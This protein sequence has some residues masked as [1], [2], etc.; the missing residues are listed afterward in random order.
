MVVTA[1]FSATGMVF[2]ACR[3]LLNMSV[4]LT[5]PL[6]VLMLVTGSLMLVKKDDFFSYLEDHKVTGQRATRGAKRPP[7]GPFVIHPPRPWPPAACRRRTMMR[8]W[9]R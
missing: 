1:F 3:C 5:V 9:T 8:T 4:L 2:P 7:R 6:T